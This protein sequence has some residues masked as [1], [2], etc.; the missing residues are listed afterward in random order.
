MIKKI[1]DKFA[2]T[3]LG[4]INLIKACISCTI[5][6]LIIAISIGI[7]YYFCIDFMIPILEHKELQISSMIYII[8]CLAV[9]ILIYIA[10]YIQYNMTFYNTYKESARLRV[11][12]AEHLRKIPLSFFG[13]RDLSDLTTTILAD[14]TYMEQ[15]LSHFIPE[16]VGSIISTTLLCLSLFIFDYRMA[17]SAVWCVPVSL[18]LVILARKKLNHMNEV[19]NQKQLYRAQMIQEGLESIRDLKANRFMNT[20]LK[21]IDNSIDDAEQQQIKNE[22]TNALFVISAQLILKLGIVSVVLVGTSLMISKQIDFSIF[23]LFLI[24]ASRLYDPLNATLQNL[25]AIISCNTKINRLNEIQNYPV[26]NGTDQF[27]PSSYD[28]E[29]DHVSFGYKENEYVIKDVSFIAKQGEITA[30][31]GESGGG[32]STCTKLAARF[33][34]VSKGKIS[35]GGID[36]QSIDPETLLSKYAIVFQDVVLFNSTIMDNIRLGKKNATDEEVLKAAKLAYCD[37]FVMKLSDGYQTVIGENGARLSGG[38][39]QRISIARALLKDAPIILLDEATASLDVESESY[40]QQALSTLIKNKTVIMIAHRM[41]TIVHADHLIVLK[42]GKIVEEGSP[43][44]LIENNGIYKHMSD[45][46]GMTHQWQI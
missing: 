14:V 29:F 21:E 35:V 42:N 10:H 31:I 16:F 19:Y 27:E 30:L 6:Y 46:Q 28:I 18:I 24:V 32:K 25:A 3:K 36:I 44:K 26:Q 8:E 7:L 13:Q 5:S 38:E 15:A 23:L 12:L 43:Q 34:D 37:E 9:A 17:L 4:A 2:L 22:L 33:W 45:I 11:T 40:V 1:Q 41:R 20:Y 39:R